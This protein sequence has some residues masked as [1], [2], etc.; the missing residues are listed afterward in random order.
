[1]KKMTAVVALT[2]VFTLAVC[3][4]I[5]G[6]ISVELM[7]SLGINEAQFGTLVMGL[8]LTGCLV[9]LIIG[10]MVDKL[11]YKPIAILGFVVTGSSMF[12]L[13]FAS[14]F[15][16]ALIACILLGAG[17]MS[18]NTVG[19]T[20][21]PVVLFKGEDPARASNFGNA[22]FGLGYVITPFLF[23]FFL[24]NLNL[25]Y[26]TSLSILG[27]LVVVFLIFALIT[28]YPQVSTGYK[29]S[30]AFKLL[31]NGAVLIAALALF[32]YMSLE[33][34]MGTWIR[35]L[36]E[37]LFGENNDPKAAFHAGL[38]LSVFGVAMMLGRFLSSTVKNL[39][40]IGIKVI[41]I[42]ALVSLG[43][44]VLMIFTNTPTLAIIAIIIAGLAF[45]PIFPTIVGVTFAKF[46]PSLYGSIFGIIFAVGLLGATFVPKFIGNLSVAQTVQQSLPIA[47]V[48]AGILF[49]LAII[50]GLTGK[51][52]A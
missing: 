27:I 34:S 36:M 5:L 2:A 18:L 17:A 47:A 38:V 52:K 21:I 49:V 15:G 14:S 48:M 28:S 51:K 42:M 45:A 43:A 50:M 11:G 30:M 1:M 29:F 7:E 24:N 13:A 44:I 31:G 41:S 8:F 22:F 33:I 35:K 3:F 19:N 6:S 40:D 4:I 46:D 9:Q 16:L 26:S 23:V 25:S 12:L 37:Q 10:P 32:C 39:T 20:L